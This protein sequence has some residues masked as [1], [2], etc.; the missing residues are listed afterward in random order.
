MRVFTYLSPVTDPS[1]RTRKAYLTY[2]VPFRPT[3][4]VIA[5]KGPAAWIL[6]Q[7]SSSLEGPPP[8]SIQ[9]KTFVLRLLRTDLGRQSR[10]NLGEMQYVLAGR[11]RFGDAALL[12]LRDR[13]GLA[14]II[15]WPTA[16][17]TRPVFF[18]HRQ[19]RSARFIG[20]AQL[21]VYSRVK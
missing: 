19:P 20:S 5:I 3:L 6:G 7:F 16:A 12:G 1:V 10:L 17:V 14:I 15:I 13:P 2:T 8:A 4:L 18:C 11:A 9:R 21:Y